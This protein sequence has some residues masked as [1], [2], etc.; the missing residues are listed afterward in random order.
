VGVLAEVRCSPGSRI[1]QLRRERVDGMLAAW[2]TAM[3][4][5]QLAIIN[6]VKGNLDTARVYLHAL[7]TTCFTTSGR[8]TI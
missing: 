3:I 1:H 7:S 5:Q 6:M 4:L 8:S 2:G